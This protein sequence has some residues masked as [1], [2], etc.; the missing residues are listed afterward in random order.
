MIDKESNTEVQRIMIERYGWERYAEESNAKLIDDDNRWG[1]LYRK[2]D[3]FFLRVTN[4]SPEPDGSFR[5]FILPV[6]R[7]CRPIPDPNDPN[8][9]FGVTQ[10]RTALNALASTFGMTG[11]EYAAI[12]GAES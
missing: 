6:D 3:L 8:G 5:E 9:E 12:I 4:S 7:R 1:K 10:E 11:V 2:G